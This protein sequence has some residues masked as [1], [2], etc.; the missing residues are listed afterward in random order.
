ML[1]KRSRILVKVKAR[2]RKPQKYK[3]GVQVTIDADEAKK[4]LNNNGNTFWKYEI[5]NEMENY[6][7]AFLLLGL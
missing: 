3:F 7:V 6:R 4:L 1:N 5:K 2:C